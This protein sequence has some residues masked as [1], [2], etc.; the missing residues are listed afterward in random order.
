MHSKNKIKSLQNRDIKKLQQHSEQWP[1]HHIMSMRTKMM[2]GMSFKE[3]HQWVLNKI[4]NTKNVICDLDYHYLLF[5]FETSGIGPIN[6]QRAIELA[7]VIL[8]RELKIIHS[9]S[10]YFQYDGE[11]NNL[12]HSDNVINNVRTSTCNNKNILNN[13]ISDIETTLKNDGNIIAHNIKF[14]LSQLYRECDSCNIYYDFS[15]YEKNFICSMNKTILFCNKKNKYKKLKFPTLKEL[16]QTCFLESPK[17][18]LHQAM[19]D[20]I[21]LVDCFKYLKQKNIL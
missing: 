19:N 2:W 17:I 20:V 4:K 1:K 18:T 9:K 8:N 5:D 7:W 12:F 6:N 15:K 11:I 16:Y 3:A 13:F 21:I 14:D 10:Y